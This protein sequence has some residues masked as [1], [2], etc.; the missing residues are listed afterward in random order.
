MRL[1]LLLP[2]YIVGLFLCFTAK[3][4][5][6]QTEISFEQIKEDYIIFGPAVVPKANL[7][8]PEQLPKSKYLAL[9]VSGGELCTFTNAVK[10]NHEAYAKA[11][12]ITY[13]YF[14]S[15]LFFKKLRFVTA[16]KERQTAHWYKVQLLKQLLAEDTIPE[17]SYILYVDDDVI[18]NDFT[19]TAP[20]FDK[21]IESYPQASMILTYDLEDAP[22]IN[23]GLI[24]LKKNNAARRI[25]EQWWANRPKTPEDKGKYRFYDQDGL[26]KLIREDPEYSNKTTI[27]VIP[28]RSGELNLNTFRSNR[29]DWNTPDKDKRVTGGVAAKTDA[30]IHHSGLEI[31]LKAREIGKTLEA[32]EASYPLIH[33]GITA[34]DAHNALA[35]HKEALLKLATA[36]EDAIQEHRDRLKFI[37][38]REYAESLVTGDTELLDTSEV[39]E[40]TLIPVDLK[41]RKI[42]GN[43]KLTRSINLPHY[44]LEITKE[45]SLNCFG[46]HIV[47]NS[48]HH[49]P[50]IIMDEGSKLLNCRLYGNGAGTGILSRENHILIKDVVLYNFGYGIDLTGADLSRFH[51]HG[52]NYGQ[53][54]SVGPEAKLIH[55]RIMNPTLGFTAPIGFRGPHNKNPLI[56]NQDYLTGCGHDFTNVKGGYTDDI[57]SIHSRSIL[58]GDKFKGSIIFT[59][60]EVVLGSNYGIPIDGI[61]E[62][63]LCSAHDSRIH[64]GHL[65]SGKNFPLRMYG[66]NN[67]KLDELEITGKEG[68][69]LLY[70]VQL[71]HL[72]RLQVNGKYYGI[73]AQGL[74]VSKL[75]FVDTTQAYKKPRFG[76]WL[77]QGHAVWIDNSRIGRFHTDDKD[78]NAKYYFYNNMLT[79][80]GEEHVKASDFSSTS[81]LYHDRFNKSSPYYNADIGNF[82]T[83]F[84]CQ[85]SRRVNQYSICIQ[86]K[87]YDNGYIKD[88]APQTR[89]PEEI[90]DN[91]YITKPGYYWLS[92][93]FDS[94]YG[95][96]IHADNVILD[97]NDYGIYPDPEHT[98]TPVIINGKNALLY[99]C[100]L[101]PGALI[102]GKYVPEVILETI[103]IKDQ[104]KDTRPGWKHPAL[105]MMTPRDLSFNF[106]EKKVQLHFYEG[107]VK[108]MT[109]STESLTG[110]PNNQAAISIVEEPDIYQTDESVTHKTTTEK[111]SVSLKKNKRRYMRYVYLQHK[112][113]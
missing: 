63:T 85:E 83:D 94:P 50:M 105:A 14:E 108:Q 58:D 75:N 96:R 102:T 15:H 72:N 5:S 10:A 87:H 69:M 25:I 47:G 78:I 42:V 54:M 51:G 82:W 71:S 29:Y 52:I 109:L 86:P 98:D 76:A 4:S 65:T 99:N 45:A 55:V 49:K 59:N 46:Y 95:L 93:N 73:F 24:I 77:S 21:I 27:S 12:G 91:G 111:N 100:Q 9:I 106:K 17:N 53:H 81:R 62:I 104:T 66:C 37:A 7:I 38:K 20:M 43:Q 39:D 60:Q 8:A 2:G 110:T 92:R 33:G 107:P 34:S 1:F 56:R 18:L 113:L 30:A 22:Y 28:Q 84:D 13:Q 23:S 64:G 41:K 90:P 6:N 57:H 79:D 44:P 74:R 67:V 48:N 88:T 70:Q 40:D 68:G 36:E 101:S 19:T 31:T 35:L 89:F 97:C 16:R 26:K 3:A 32:V 103:Y 11:R 80:P 112:E 61:A